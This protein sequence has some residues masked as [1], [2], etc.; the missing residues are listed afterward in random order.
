M[1]HVEQH[2]FIH[3]AWPRNEN[4][5]LRRNHQFLHSTLKVNAKP[6]M[7]ANEANVNRKREG[8]RQR[9]IE[10]EREK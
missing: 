6:S 8:E 9:E 2:T 4:K 7:A 1:E 10:E 3:L 5:L